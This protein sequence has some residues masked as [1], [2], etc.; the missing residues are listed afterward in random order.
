[1]DSI[2]FILTD[3]RKLVAPQYQESFFDCN[4]FL[5]KIITENNKLSIK[6]KKYH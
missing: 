4:Q 2:I 1:M 6:N 5:K 3:T